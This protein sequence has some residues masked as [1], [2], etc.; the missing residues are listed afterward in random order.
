MEGA[1]SMSVDQ[2]I[3]AAR[4]GDRDRV[5]ALLDEDPSLLTAANMF[6][7]QAV[8]AA[9]FSGQHAIVDLLFSRGLKLDYFLVAELGMLD[10]LT[11]QSA[12]GFNERGSTALHGACYWGQ[13]TAAR[14]L[15]DHGADPNVA[16]RDE[17][18]QIRPLGAAVA[19]PDVPNPSDDE[20]VVLELV[21]LL[22]ERGADVNGRRRDGLTAL[23]GAAYRGHC[24][25]IRFLLDHGADCELKGEAG[26]H[27]GQT[28]RDVANTRGESSAAGLI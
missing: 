20:G 5:A 6:G 10:R 2:L 11:P 25:V 26:P 28:A 9:H 12:H 21:R 23:H 22:I 7:T 14:F 27:V 24:E 13:P 16:T 3:A 17:F 18:L 15:L 4:A 1:E 19:T 8:H